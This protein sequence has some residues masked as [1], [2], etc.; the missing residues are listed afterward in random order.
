MPGATKIAIIGLASLICGVASI[1][2]T[3]FE[4]AVSWAGDVLRLEGKTDLPDGTKLNLAIVDKKDM[5]T[6]VSDEIIFSTVNQGKFVASG[7]VKD[8]KPFIAGGY[9]L[10]IE[11]DDDP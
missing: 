6:S 8:K 2:A 3:S 1:R 7:F 10:S 9:G 11:H 5:N 4:V